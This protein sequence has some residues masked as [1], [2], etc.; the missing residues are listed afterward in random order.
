MS[1]PK[2]DIEWAR[3]VARMFKRIKP[4]GHGGRGL[5]GN[6]NFEAAFE[7]GW[8]DAPANSERVFEHLKQMV[9]SD[10]NLARAVITHD[11]VDGSGVIELPDIARDVIAKSVQS[12]SQIA[13]VLADLE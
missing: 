7:G 9:R 4:E 2:T 6:R 11:E 3:Y 13:D 12:P 10:L 8:S 1:R 5:S